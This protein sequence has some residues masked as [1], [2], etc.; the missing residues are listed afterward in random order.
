MGYRTAFT[1]QV[2][3]FLQQ[4]GNQ[5]DDGDTKTVKSKQCAERCLKCYIELKGTVELGGNSL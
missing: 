1:E 4:L 5:F 2:N 3:C